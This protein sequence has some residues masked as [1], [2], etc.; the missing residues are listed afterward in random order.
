MNK[1]AK[2]RLDVMVLNGKVNYKRIKDTLIT[3]MNSMGLISDRKSEVMLN[4]NRYNLS[5][6]TRKFCERNN[7]D[8]LS[9][10]QK[11]IVA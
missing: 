8:Y 10:L 11:S 6:E 4:V 2:T 5:Q 3:R 7:I 1:N 9:V